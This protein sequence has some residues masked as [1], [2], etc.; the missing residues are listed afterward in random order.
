[1]RSSRAC[2][3][4]ATRTRST[5]CLHAGRAAAIRSGAENGPLQLRLLRA[6]PV[7]E[8]ASGKSYAAYMADDLF[9]PLGVDDVKLGRGL[10]RER[11]PREVS[12]P[13]KD[14]LTE[15]TDSYG[16]LVASAPSLCKFLEAYWANGKPR[17]PGDDF[18]WAYF[19]NFGGTTAFIRQRPDGYNVAVLCNGSRNASLQD[20][21]DRGLGRLVEEAIDKFAASGK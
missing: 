15:V 12:Y 9:Q 7:I 1:M 10:V 18:Q 20:E 2:A 4:P 5:S 3:F 13:V 8:K 6:G 11:D 16:G 17:H 21:D 19:G 14:V